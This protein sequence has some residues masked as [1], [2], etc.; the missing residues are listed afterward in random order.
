MPQPHFQTI[1]NSNPSGQTLF[2]PYFRIFHLPFARALLSRSD[3]A[4]SQYINENRHVFRHLTMAWMKSSDLSLRV[5]RF[6]LLSLCH[7]FLS[8][9]VSFSLFF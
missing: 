2:S 4:F 8:P 7:S 3:D 1:E 9:S 6:H 5:Q